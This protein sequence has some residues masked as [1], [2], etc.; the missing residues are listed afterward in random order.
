M[1]F[2]TVP[3]ALRAARR[4]AADA[5]GEL[6]AVDCGEPVGTL[7]AAMPGGTTAGIAPTSG[8]SWTTAFKA[9]CIDAD[10]HAENLEKA[11]DSYQRADQT[12]GD[13]LTSAGSPRG[14]R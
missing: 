11:A 13:E 8:R 6:R 1:G 2:R 9:W 14:P 5:V 12:G 7:A 3:E 4:S 10:A